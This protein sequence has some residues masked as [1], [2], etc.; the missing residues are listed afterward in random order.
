MS[1]TVN[2]NYPV[3]HPDH[4]QRTDAARIAAA[5]V[6]I[7]ADVAGLLLMLGGKANSDAIG[8]AVDAAIDALKA[9]APAALDTLAEIASRLA[10]NDDAV[11]ALVGAIASK[12]SQADHNALA[13]DVTALAAVV[14]TKANAGNVYSRAYLDERFAGAAA[15]IAADTLAADGGRYIADTSVG[16]VVVTLP[17]APQRGM[18]VTIWREGVNAV[19]I[20]RGG[21]TIEGLAENLTL[22]VNKKGVRLTYLFGTWAAF[23]EV[24]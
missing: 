21:K 1:E 12:A 22:D 14:G 19:T 23:P 4:P 9:G 6:A 24:L 8:A 16:A 15:V 17:A 10:D 13:A 20:A 18:H 11:A 5:L 7:D 3:P 2:R